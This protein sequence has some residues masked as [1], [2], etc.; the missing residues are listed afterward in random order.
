[1]RRAIGVAHVQKKGEMQKQMSNLGAQMTAERI[2]RI[3][4]EL[5][6]FE[7]DLRALAEKYKNEIKHDPV[8]RAR[9]RQLADSLGI[10]LLSSK[11]NI[12]S[13][14]LGLG[15]FYYGLGSR[16]VEV[17]MKE[18]KFCGSYIPLKRVVFFMKKLYEGTETNGKQNKITEDDIRMA[19]DK[20][21][22]LGDGYSIVKLAGVN[23]IQT[24]P[25]GMCSSD[26]ALLLNV[27]L[28][29]QARQIADFRSTRALGQS[30]KSG[31]KGNYHQ[32]HPVLGAH[33]LAYSAVTRNNTNYDETTYEDEN[34]D[35]PLEIQ[36]VA[37]TQKE[38]ERRLMWQPHR[39]HDA[40]DRM[41]QNGSVWIEQPQLAQFLHT[42]RNMRQ[43]TITEEELMNAE[44]VYWF[45]AFMLQ[46][47]S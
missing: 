24:T 10:D 44:T 31:R 14:I 25:D 13:G 35:I 8:V 34:A 6:S 21:R 29:E 27:V 41:V 32:S 38:I 30:V 45:I 33:Y 47:N 46:E 2:G 7:K 37:L 16:V 17:C 15:D 28:E 22:V 4:D 5:E 19:L 23:Y 42:K 11:K 39:A 43:S 1:M 9:F 20:L 40:L 3:A 12:F 18:R 26:D 36:C